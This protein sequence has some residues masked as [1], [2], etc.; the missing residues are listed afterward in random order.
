MH[1]PLSLLNR[2]IAK[3]VAAMFDY[4]AGGDPDIP[5][6]LATFVKDEALPL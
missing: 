6:P 5:P 3:E 1:I 4:V 2:K